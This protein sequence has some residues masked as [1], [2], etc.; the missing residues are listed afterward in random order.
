LTS[1]NLHSADLTGAILH[2]ANL[3]GTTLQYAN[4]HSADLTGANLTC[5]DLTNMNLTY[6]NLTH[7]NLTGAC[8]AN[9]NLTDANLTC[10]DLT[11][12]YLHSN[13]HSANLAG[14]ICAPGAGVIP[15]SDAEILAAGLTIRG[16][17]VYGWRTQRS[18]HCGDTFYEVGKQYF[19]P[20]FSVDPKEL[21]H[22]GIYLA[23]KQWL[24]HN[25]GR[26]PI[27]R[28]CCNRHDLVHAGDK[29]RASKIWVVG[30]DQPA[31][32]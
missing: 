31:D 13:L 4:L 5:A 10:A 22:P 12:A 3:A 6:A 14:T 25:Y 30:D 28:V 7:A 20:V 15:A 26:E 9:A 17:L 21:C 2:S 8:L 11:F 16:S 24:A 32:E 18:Q 1:T 27:V 19:A 29:W 23:G